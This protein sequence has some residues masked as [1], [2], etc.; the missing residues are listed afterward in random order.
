MMWPDL[1]NGIFEAGGAWWLRQ[2]VKALR[3]DRSIKGVYWPARCYFAAW[4]VWNLAYYPSL[5]QWASFSGGVAIVLVNVYW[6]YL[7]WRFTRRA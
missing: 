6:C 1:I 3:R 4:G 5:G 7:A 2:D